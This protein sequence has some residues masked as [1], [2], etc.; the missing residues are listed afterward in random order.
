VRRALLPLPP[1]PLLPLL[2]LRPPAHSRHFTQQRR[3]KDAPVVPAG[4]QINTGQV[5]RRVTRH[6]GR[7]DAP[8]D[9]TWRT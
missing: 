2:R 6:D 9:R 7:R 4:Q 1:L 8:C 5:R 3:A